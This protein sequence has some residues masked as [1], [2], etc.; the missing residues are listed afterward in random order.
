MRRVSV[1]VAT[2]RQDAP[3]A[4]LDPLWAALLGLCV[5][6]SL[7]GQLPSFHALLALVAGG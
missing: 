3:S 4:S 6:L 5:G 7:G 2:L 1:R